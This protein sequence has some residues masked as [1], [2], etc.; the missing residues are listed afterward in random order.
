MSNAL[1]NVFSVKHWEN[2]LNDFIMETHKVPI[3]NLVKYD[4][5]NLEVQEINTNETNY[6]HIGHFN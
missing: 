3:Y 6:Q 2:M 5:T 4:L 1:S